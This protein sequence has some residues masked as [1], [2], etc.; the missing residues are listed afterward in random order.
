MSSNS[1]GFAKLGKGVLSLIGLVL[2]Y[3]WTTFVFLKL[4]GWFVLPTFPQLPVLSMPVAMGL[5]STSRFMAYTGTSLTLKDHDSDDYKLW[6]LTFIY[7]F[8]VL[9]AGWVIKFFV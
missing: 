2:S 1:D 9:T 3:L 6:S 7:P 5:L 4:W 8:I